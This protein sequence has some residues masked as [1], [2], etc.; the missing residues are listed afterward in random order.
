MFSSQ[1]ATLN[2]V[3]LGPSRP[4]LMACPKVTPVCT[5]LVDVGVGVL[6]GVRVGVGVSVG[7]AVLVGVKLGSI[8][9][10]G[11]GRNVG[12]SANVG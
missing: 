8:K 7:V 10:V 5:S 12:W 3:S 1:I 11:C 2:C 9:N 6:V 4:M